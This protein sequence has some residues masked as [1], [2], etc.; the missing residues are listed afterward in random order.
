MRL[1]KLQKLRVPPPLPPRQE[2]IVQDAP[3]PVVQ[4]RDWNERIA[5]TLTAIMTW[6]SLNP[7]YFLSGCLHAVVLTVMALLVFSRPHD[8]PTVG[9]SSVFGQEQGAEEFG[10]ALDNVAFQM[11]A[12]DDDKPAASGEMTDQMVP[13]GFGAGTG[14]TGSGSGDSDS[15]GRGDIEIKV[16]FFGSSSEGQSFVFIVDRSGSMGDEGRFNRAISELVKT[17]NSLKPHQT[18][19]VYFFSDETIGLFGALQA[20]AL[21]PATPQNKSR[22]IRWIKSKIKPGGQTDPEFALQEA[23][24]LK[25]DVIYLLT[26]GVFDDPDFIVAMVRNRNA[27]GTTVHTIA[28]KDESGRECLE[29]IAKQNKGTYRFVK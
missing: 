21:I 20:T 18:F 15:D 17:I 24:L 5:L 7:W 29:Q 13:I 9:I 1:S 16:G 2:F 19:F 26:D 25:P 14:T 23:L 8:E 3:R 4:P 10:N 27:Q 11:P 22:A 12:I 28:L 6:I